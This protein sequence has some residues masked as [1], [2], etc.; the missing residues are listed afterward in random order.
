MGRD[1]VRAGEGLDYARGFAISD[2]SVIAPD[3]WPT[4]RLDRRWQLRWDPRNPV[5][6]SVGRDEQVILVGRSI[7]LGAPADDAAAI[8]ERLRS[9]L[10]GRGGSFQDEVDEL[11]GRFVVIRIEHGEL[12]LQNDAAGM[13][14][15]AF[16][17]EGP[18][19][20][21][22]HT[23]LV[24]ENIGIRASELA[25]PSYFRDNG[26][27]QFPAR[28][29]EYAGVR[30][31]TPNTEL[32]LAERRVER[33]FPRRPVEPTTLDEAA[34]TIIEA[35]DAQAR[36][37]Q[38]HDRLLL[39]ISAGVDSR[40]SLALLRGI[41]P[42]LETY[43]YD[44]TYA[45]KNAGNRYDRDAAEAIGILA[46]VRHTTL[47]VED[48]EPNR[49]LSAALHRNSRAVHSRKLAAAYVE[50]LPVDAVHVRSHVHGIVKGY[51]QNFNYGY[52]EMDGATLARIASAGKAKDE[53]IARAFEEYRTD[54][55]FDERFD[56]SPLDLLYWEYRSALIQAP[57]LLE[58]DLVVDTHALLSSRRVLARLL[59]LPLADRRGAR[60]FLRII[61]MRWPELL[62]IPLNGRDVRSEGYR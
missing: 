26:M 9:S 45:V 12:R 50:R 13:R 52:S 54:T 56:Y 46:G 19:V 8:A 48:R 47:A 34:Q 36:A 5:A 43:T 18:H 30:S 57:A 44:L 38:Q 61:E 10:A 49:R 14:T 17:T 25:Y 23:R 37:L 3:H 60:V 22:S 7:H 24:A 31:L 58:S 2:E 51:Y 1:A 40:S 11:C 55:S 53:R 20:A 21:A 27:F 32:I 59:G 41:A 42:K 6:R 29:T 15:V 62:D 16:S 28:H 33:I 35:S 4:L 39:S